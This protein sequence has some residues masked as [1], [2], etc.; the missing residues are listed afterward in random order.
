MEAGEHHNCAI[1]GTC[2]EDSIKLENQLE[3]S[4][5]AKKQIVLYSRKY[6]WGINFGGLAVLEANFQIKIRRYNYSPL[7]ALST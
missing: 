2:R 3:Y 7:I 1:R 5:A 6:S 4:N